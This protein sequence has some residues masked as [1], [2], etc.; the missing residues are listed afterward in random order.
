VDY[1]TKKGGCSSLPQCEHY[2][3]GYHGSSDGG[4]E[5]MF[6]CKEFVSHWDIPSSIFFVFT[7]FT[8]IGYPIKKKEKY[9]RTYS[10]ICSILCVLYSPTTLPFIRFLCFS[11]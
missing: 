2:E 1:L 8:T 11:T 3:D 5:N 10:I 6:Y 7:L 4:S 9:K